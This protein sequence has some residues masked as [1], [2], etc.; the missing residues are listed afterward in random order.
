MMP[1]EEQRLLAQGLADYVDVLN[2][3]SA[4]RSLVQGTFRLVVEKNLEGYAAALGIDLSKRNVLD[5]EYSDGEFF[6]LGVRCI[7][8]RVVYTE[9]GHALYWERVDRG[10]FGTGIYIWVWS[11]RTNIERLREVLRQKGVHHE[12]DGQVIWLGKEM[13]ASDVGRI[14]GKLDGLMEKW[15]KLWRKAGGLKALGGKS[16]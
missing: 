2:A 6:S 13:T 1:Q 15:I 16:P 9:L 4:F 11:R 12:Q 8:K 7:D 5:H 3:M 10:G 14:E